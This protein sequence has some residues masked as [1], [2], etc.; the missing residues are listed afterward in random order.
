MSAWSLER[1]GQNVTASESETP[2]GQLRVR[3]PALPFTGFSGTGG[4]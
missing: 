3:R 2:A 4:L 1:Y